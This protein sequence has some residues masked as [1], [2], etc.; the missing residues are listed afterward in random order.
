MEKII[1]I[2]LILCSV[3][4]ADEFIPEMELGDNWTVRR[5]I[6]GIENFENNKNKI[7]FWRYEVVSKIE[8]NKEEYLVIFATSKD[9]NASIKIVVNKESFNIK[10]ISYTNKHKTIVM[11]MGEINAP[12]IDINILARLYDLP[13]FPINDP[14]SADKNTYTDRKSVV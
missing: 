13:A 1:F 10:E 8:F 7:Q 11:D 9:V 12:V 5:E 3:T 4:F 2:I 6:S 14:N